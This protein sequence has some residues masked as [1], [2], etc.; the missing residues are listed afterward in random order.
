[1]DVKVAVVCA[2]TF[3]GE[4]E[5]KNAERALGYLEEAARLGAKLICFPKGYPGPC[6]GPLDFGGRLPFH[7]LEAIQEKAK[8][9][10]V[11]VCTGGLEIDP[12]AADSYFLSIKLISPQGDILC[13]YRSV[14][15]EHPELN[16]LQLAG[17]KKIKPG[18][19]I[20]VVETELGKIG[21]QIC[22]EL[23]VPE[24]SR[25]QM[26]RGADIVLAPAG[27]F[28]RPTQLRL[29]KTWRC[30]AHARASENLF[31]VVVPH[32]VFS[33]GGRAYDAKIGCIASPEEFLAIAEGPG[34][35]LANLN[36]ERLQWLRQ[37][38]S[39]QDW[40]EVPPDPDNFRPV[41]TRPGQSRFRRPELYGELTQPTTN[42]RAPSV[43]RPGL[44]KG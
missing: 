7:P 21:L 31:F 19:G 3:Y 10:R 37:G 41:K 36:L 16:S 17:R 13:N 30:I 28:W 39:E 12:E 15:P 32:S 25:I 9:H 34:V 33:V 22:S 40:L 23:F 35:W 1:M 27:G 11:Y 29:G 26:L 42:L 14:Q 38:Y 2:E 44:I 6:H 8:Q 18:D 20:A 43:S 4:E 24:L 5:Y